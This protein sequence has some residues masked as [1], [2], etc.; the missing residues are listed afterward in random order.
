MTTLTQAKR[1]KNVLL[2]APILAVEK[3]QRRTVRNAERVIVD[4][5]VKLPTG[6]FIKKNAKQE[7]LDPPL[8][9]TILNL[10]SSSITRKRP[11]FVASS[12]L[13]D[14]TLLVRRQQMQISS[15]EAVNF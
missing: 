5:T 12:M 3:L 15:T 11:N 13:V 4:A 10:L 14:N 9:M 6:Q 2:S 8:K 1:Q 7:L